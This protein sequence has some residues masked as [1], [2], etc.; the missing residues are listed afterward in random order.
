VD[1]I[2]RLFRA[3]GGRRW[4]VRRLFPYFSVR[5]IQTLARKPV[6]AYVLQI[7]VVAN[8]MGGKD[9]H[10][11]G[12]RVL[13]PIECVGH[14]VTDPDAYSLTAEKWVWTTIRFRFKRLDSKCLRQ[15]DSIVFMTSLR[16][17]NLSCIPMVVELSR[18]RGVICHPLVCFRVIS[19]LPPFTVVGSDDSYVLV[20]LPQHNLLQ[21]I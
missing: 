7:I 9:T 12:L 13:G 18:A 20:F 8:H 1:Y 21:P 5:L 16:S 19:P 4:I 6:Y 11:R 10:V 3:N 14:T 2:R 15:F 17:A